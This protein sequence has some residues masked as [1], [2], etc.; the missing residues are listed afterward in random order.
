MSTDL[1]QEA[2]RAAPDPDHWWTIRRIKGNVAAVVGI[3]KAPDAETAIKVAIEE[4]EIV[5][6]ARKRLVAQ[7]R[8]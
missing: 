6:E 5:G 7:R 8:S 3:V 1:R 4:F 2:K